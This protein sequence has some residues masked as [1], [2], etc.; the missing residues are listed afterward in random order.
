MIRVR[1]ALAFL[2]LTA[3]AW[4]EVPLS[5]SQIRE[6]SISKTGLTR[7]SVKGD[8]IQD[9]FV[10]PF[11]AGSVAMSEVIQLHKSGHV[12]IAPEGLKEPFY[13]TVMTQKGQVQDLKLTPASQKNVPLVLTFPEREATPEEVLQKDR[14]ILDAYLLAALQGLPPRGFTQ[15]ALT[16]PS[17]HQMGDLMVKPMSEYTS[18]RYRLS[19][20]EL[21]NRG[22]KD[23]SLMPEIFLS[24]EDLA[25]SFEQ[26]VL[27]P[28]GKGRM[29]ILTTSFHLPTR[30][31]S[32]SVEPLSHSLQGEK[33]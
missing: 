2:A 6:V 19:V 16:S 8:V 10:Y 3:T 25:V 20:F 5:E 9:I 13:L 33:S 7:L 30:E 32:I 12:F 18:E 1:G 28:Q 11:M 24:S 26:P 22:D 21:E 17:V 31:N 23:L 27:E 15:K 4:G 14:K 29:A